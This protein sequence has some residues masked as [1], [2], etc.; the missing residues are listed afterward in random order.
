M[1][2]DLRPYLKKDA[3]DILILNELS[4]V[5]VTQNKHF[6]KI[7]SFSIVEIIFNSVFQNKIII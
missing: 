3:C 2:Y 6:F 7:C 4:H 5:R 1:N